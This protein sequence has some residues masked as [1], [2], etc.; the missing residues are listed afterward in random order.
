MSRLA[1]RTALVTGST[2]GIGRAIAESYAVEGAKVIVSGRRGSVGAEVVDGIRDKGGAAEFLEAD[3]RG[4]AAQVARD[5]LEVARGRIDI[6][7]NN[8]A[9]L[10]YPSPTGDVDIAT[11]DEAMAVNVRAPF[12]LTGVLAPLMAARGAGVVLNIGSV[13]AFTGMAGSALYSLG[14]TALHSATQSWAAEYGRFGVR[15]NA[16]A[17]GPSETDNNLAHADNFGPILSQT[18][19]GRMSRLEEQAAAAVFLTVDDAANIHGI[20]LPV[21]G[22]FAAVSRVWT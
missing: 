3:L 5:A 11:F 16:L 4:D 14:K 22:G 7:V 13:N 1:G 21:D 8:A 15:V 20:V 12:L 19:S 10:T 6:L 9:F 17:P 18:A 2:S